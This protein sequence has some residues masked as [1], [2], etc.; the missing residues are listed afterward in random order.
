M[1]LQGIQTTR[2]AR[3]W[4]LKG[5]HGPRLRELFDRYP[6]ATVLFIHRD[7]VQVTAS[8]IAMAADL[9]EGLVGEFDLADVARAH[10]AASR[11]EFAAILANP[12][13]D[14]PRVLHVHYRDFMAD[15]VA[16]VRRYFEFAGHTWTEEGEHAMRRYLAENR[17]DRYGKF[18]YST[19]LIG[20]DVDALHEEFAPYRERF[21]IEIERRG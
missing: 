20:D 2:P 1:M 14:D 5:F 16:V 19:D 21:G 8:R 12:M 7:P 9:H 18:A 13:V 17:G 15:Q 11:A 10:L 6:D 3:R 4:V